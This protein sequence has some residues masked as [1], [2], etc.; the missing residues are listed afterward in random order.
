MIQWP[1]IIKHDGEDELIYVSSLSE[2]QRDEEMLLYIFTERD[3]LIDSSGQV[4]SLTDVQ[5]NIADNNDILDNKCLATVNADNIM[6]L[7][8]AHAAIIGSCCIEKMH[9]RSAIQ[10]IKLV[11][12]LTH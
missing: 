3:I 10:A 5:Q 6:E 9:A 8:R 12:D 2:W 7:V 1:A 11:K 4:F